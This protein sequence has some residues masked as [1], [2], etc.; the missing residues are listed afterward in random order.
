MKKMPN[1]LSVALALLLVVSLGTIQALATDDEDAAAAFGDEAAFGGDDDAFGLAGGDEAARLGEEFAVMGASGVAG[2]AS[3]GGEEG[4]GGG[5]GEEKVR[6][7]GWD[8][9][10]SEAFHC[11][12]VRPG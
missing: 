1:I 10:F 5:D 4:E 12:G 11:R 3:G 7:H 9:C 8:S 2:R 6:L